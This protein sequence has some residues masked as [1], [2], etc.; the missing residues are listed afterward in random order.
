MD[1]VTNMSLMH[2]HVTADVYAALED[3]IGQD[4]DAD[5]NAA[6]LIKMAGESTA[7]A[8]VAMVEP[9]DAVN[10]AVNTVKDQR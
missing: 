2:P 3:A 7:E 9:R 4:L 8:V 10:D 5:T 1:L 6:R